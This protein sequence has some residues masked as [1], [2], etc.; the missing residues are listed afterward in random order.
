MNT[1]N[2]PRETLRRRALVAILKHAF[3]RWESA[4]V[5][6]L[7]LLLAYFAPYPLPFWQPWF[8]LAGAL[9]AEGVLAV[10]T[11]AN[12][13][14]NARVVARLLRQEF[15]LGRLRAG[16]P[17]ARVEQALEYRRRIE[18]ALAAQRA[19]VLREHL[20]QVAIDIEQWI[21]NIYGLAV[22]LDRYEHDDLVREDLRRVPAALDQLQARLQAED[23]PAV[24]AQIAE[25]IRGREA[26]LAS[27]RTLE[28]TMERAGYQL[29][30]TLTALGTVYSQLLLVG[31]RDIDSS[32][33]QR[34]RQDI[35]EQVAALQDL[36][37]SLDEVYGRTPQGD[38]EL[39]AARERL[40]ARGADRGATDRGAP[41]RDATDRG[42]T[43]RGATGSGAR[44]GGTR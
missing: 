8:W 13:E 30:Q 19:G 34:L 31:V 21:A 28:S 42:A 41:D 17:R 24:R 29:E 37:S 25:T 11:L 22:K 40:G 43:D 26:Q 12:P 7:G 18:D 16:E 2:G 44:G 35:A 23:D 32:R 3:F 20:N 5:I 15:D 4:I 6:A 14:I 1:T 33:A 39:A 10:A 27:L 9:A 36:S 38:D